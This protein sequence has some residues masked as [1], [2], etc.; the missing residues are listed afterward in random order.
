MVEKKLLFKGSSGCIFR[1]KLKCHND[2]K[3]K[4]K[5]TKRTKRRVKTRKKGLWGKSKS[6]VTKLMFDRNN[7]EY[8]FNKIIKKI[9]NYKS[10]TSLWTSVCESPPYSKLIGD[11][12]INECIKHSNIKGL[13]IDSSFFLQQ[14]DYNGDDLNQYCKETLS[15]EILTDQLKFNEYFVKLFRLM[16]NV[17][18]G[19]T[20]LSKNGI[21]HHDINIRN[22]LIKKNKSYIIDYDIALK[23][24][25]VGENKFLKE[26][27]NSEYSHYR[28]YE[29]YP[30]E[31]LYH[32]LKSQSDV[33]REIDNIKSHQ[34]LIGYYELYLPIN[35]GVFGIDTNKQRY[36][37]LKNKSERSTLA[38]RSTNLTNLMKKLDIYSLGMMILIVF[39]DASLRNDVP[40]DE[41][42]KRLR[43]PELKSYT[44]LIEDM[45][46]FDHRDRVTCEIAYKR[47]LNLIR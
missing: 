13:Y 30:F 15:K 47:Y 25:S 41:I 21:C 27:M 33:S 1:P 24:K 11:S 16:K 45:I 35:E 18:Y 6:K 42:I 5:R 3:K 22:I 46:K 8:D 39:F 36:A 9:K 29:A 26:R 43:S 23:I 2:T 32:T 38:K 17:F 34:S 40:V 28:L 20:Q 12:D 37:Y 4:T 31:Y 10:W 44:D 7:K 14:G 19:L